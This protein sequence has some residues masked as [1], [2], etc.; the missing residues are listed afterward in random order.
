[1]ELGE[2]RRNKKKKNYAIGP[3]LVLNSLSPPT[4]T[5]YS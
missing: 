4:H 5:M 1:M 3:Y 2:G